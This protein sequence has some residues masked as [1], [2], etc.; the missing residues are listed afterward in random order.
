MRIHTAR[1]PQRF[2]SLCLK[3]TSSPGRPGSPAWLKHQ[4]GRRLRSRAFP[5]GCC[6]SPGA[7]GAPRAQG[8]WGRTGRWNPEPARGLGLRRPGSRHTPAPPRPP[9]SD[10]VPPPLDLGARCKKRKTTE[11]TSPGRC[12]SKTRGARV[13]RHGA[14]HTMRAQ[15]ED[16]LPLITRA[17]ARAR[18]PLHS[19]QNPRAALLLPSSKK[20]FSYRSF[21]HA[22]A[23]K[24]E[25]SSGPGQAGAPR[26]RSRAPLAR[27]EAGGKRLRADRAGPQ[28]PKIALEPR[29]ASATRS[30]PAWQLG[31]ARARGGHGHARRPGGGA[32]GGEPPRARAPACG[33]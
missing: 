31:A 20:P 4:C 10:R 16:W 1:K 29:A 5:G 22:P 27:G 33:R 21:R 30:R 24:G 14:W 11:P 28:A 23:P 2:L 3:P 8:P 6:P 7:R 12:G 17:R 15:K 9:A 19:L 25:A 18:L 32:G 13:A 26:R